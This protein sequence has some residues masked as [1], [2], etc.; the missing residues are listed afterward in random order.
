MP[1]G[2]NVYDLNR[3]NEEDSLLY[4]ERN[5][6]NKQNLQKGKDINHTGGVLHSG[7]IHSPSVILTGWN[8]SC[9]KFIFIKKVMILELSAPLTIIIDRR[10][11]IDIHV[12]F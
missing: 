8:D 6:C 4:T 12:I 2:N 5:D 9:N 1:L 10:Q 3:S 11:Y 7:T